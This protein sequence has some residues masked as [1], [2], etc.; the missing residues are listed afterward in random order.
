[1]LDRAGFFLAAPYMQAMRGR[2][3]FQVHLLASVEPTGQ[4][5]AQ[6]ALL[7]A[8]GWEIRGI[9]PA[10]GGG[11]VVALQRPFGEEHPLPDG[12]TLAASLEEPLSAP[13][14]ADMEG[15]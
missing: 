8:L 5:G 3:E 9:A 6:L 12:A 14:I 10:A 1:M 11:F 2:F 13:M 4:P 7:G 15:P